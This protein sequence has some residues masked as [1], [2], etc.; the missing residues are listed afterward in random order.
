M[1]VFTAQ[2]EGCERVRGA[3]CRALAALA[4]LVMRF[5]EFRSSLNGQHGWEHGCDVPP[6][7]QGDSGAFSPGW[8]IP[9]GQHHVFCSCHC[10]STCVRVVVS[11]GGVVHKYSLDLM[12]CV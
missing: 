8:E 1:G 6:N 10:V 2:T 11:A 3:Q 7:T 4:E 9:V 12:W 5:G